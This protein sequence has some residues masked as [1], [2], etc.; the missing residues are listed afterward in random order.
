MWSSLS[1]C[2]FLAYSIVSVLRQQIKP[3][4]HVHG[5]V[6]RKHWAPKNTFIPDYAKMRCIVRAPRGE[7]KAL[8]ERVKACLECVCSLLLAPNEGRLMARSP[9]RLKRR[10]SCDGQ[11][12]RRSSPSLHLKFIPTEP[13]GG[14]HTPQFTKAAGMLEVHWLVIKT[15]KALALTGFRVVDDAESVENVRR[16]VSPLHSERA[17]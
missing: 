9:L 11:S 13:N 15:I 7:V 16:F 4:R 5:V 17:G 1:T 14:D 2:A 6:S 12:S 3:T 10:C 8:R